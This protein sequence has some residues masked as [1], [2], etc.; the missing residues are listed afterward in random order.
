MNIVSLSVI[1]EK[2]SLRDE[3]PTELTEDKRYRYVLKITSLCDYF[4]SF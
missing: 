4:D 1:Y 2:L 3:I